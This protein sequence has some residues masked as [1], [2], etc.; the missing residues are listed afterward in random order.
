M[1]NSGIDKAQAG[2][3]IAQR[4]VSNIK[5]ADDTTLMAEKEKERTT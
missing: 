2:I 5:Y 3:N 1:C 4:N